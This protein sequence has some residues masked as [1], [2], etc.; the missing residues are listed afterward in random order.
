MNQ[1]AYVAVGKKSLISSENVKEAMNHFVT[2]SPSYPIMAS[3]DFAKDYM[4]K[5]GK[6]RIENLF[7]A[8]VHF[9]KKID[10]L[11]G[12]SV[13]KQVD[14]SEFK[15]VLKWVI[16]YRASGLDAMTINKALHQK[17]VYV[18]AVD[19]HYI[20][21]LLSPAIRKKALR[22]F[23]CVL[24][25]LQTT[26]KTTDAKPTYAFE[27]LEWRKPST[28]ETAWVEIGKSAG[29]IAAKPIAVYPPGVPA[30]LEGQVLT[31]DLLQ[32]IQRAKAEGLSLVGLKDDLIKVYGDK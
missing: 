3:I 24:K 7:Y 28:Q 2:T 30:V 12:F 20:L 1:S 26:G 9:S 32:G 25:K 27:K 15:D 8:V 6:R 14:K 31:Q 19:P 23:Y 5:R 16:D 22:K 17:R 10:E 4:A 18:E 21:L 13:V 11:H 29:K